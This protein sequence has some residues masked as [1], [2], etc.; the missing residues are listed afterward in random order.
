MTRTDRA[1]R[2]SYAENRTCLNPNI[3]FRDGGN[4]ALPFFF[5]KR[6]NREGFKFWGMHL[7]NR[8][9]GHVWGCVSEDCDWVV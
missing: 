7:F 5:R 1:S 3:L 9:A 4:F 2:L 8:L 6:H